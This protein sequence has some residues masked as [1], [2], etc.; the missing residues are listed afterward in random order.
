MAT[1]RKKEEILKERGDQEEGSVTKRALSKHTSVQCYE[2]VRTEDKFAKVK[3]GQGTVSSKMSE[4]TF[5]SSGSASTMNAINMEDKYQISDFSECIK[6]AHDLLG[7]TAAD[8]RAGLQEDLF[9]TTVIETHKEQTPMSV[10]IVKNYHNEKKGTEENTKMKELQ[11]HQKAMHCS[12]SKTTD[13]SKLAKVSYN[14]MFE[15]T[16]AASKKSCTLKGADFTTQQ[17]KTDFSDSIKL[18]LLGNQAN[19]KT[20]TGGHK[21]FGI[22]GYDINK[23]ITPKSVNN[24]KN[25]HDEQAVQRRQHI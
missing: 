16:C 19:N 7:P 9:E 1:K 3:V 13:L 25:C 12:E 6:L 8:K 20:T 24:I 4:P 2:V 10:D 14:D 5:A 23:A 22:T 15:A 18:D 11:I 21:I 17:K